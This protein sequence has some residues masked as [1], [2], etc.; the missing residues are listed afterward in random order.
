[1]LLLLQSK[2][3]N[4]THKKCF[5]IH[6]CRGNCCKEKFRYFSKLKSTAEKETRGSDNKI[7]VRNQ[8]Q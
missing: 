5:K 8:S 2:Y 6:K 4:T 7:L 1:M 3:N